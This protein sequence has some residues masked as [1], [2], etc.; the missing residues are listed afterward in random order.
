MPSVLAANIFSTFVAS[1]GRKYVL[2]IKWNR[3]T[4]LYLRMLNDCVW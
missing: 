2:Q 3:W 4:V 1:Q